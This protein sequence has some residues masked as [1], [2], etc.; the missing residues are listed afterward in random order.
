MRERTVS[1]RSFCRLSACLLLFFVALRGIYPGV[2]QAGGKLEAVVS[3]LPLK[4]FVEQIAGDRVKVSVMVEPGANPATYEPKPRQMAS[5]SHASMYFSIGVPFERTWLDRFRQIN[6]ELRIIPVQQGIRLYPIGNE[7]PGK[8]IGNRQH[9]LKDP[10][11]WLSPPLVMVQ[12]RNILFALMQDMPEQSAYLYDR[13]RK[14]IGLVVSTD[15][16]IMDIFK[17]SLKKENGRNTFLVFHPCWGYFAR[18]Y[19]L[20][21]LVIEQQG[22]EP[23]P[24]QLARITREAARAGMM[25]IFVQPQFS[26]R[27]ARAVADSIGA[28]LVPADPLAYDWDANLISVALRIKEALR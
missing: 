14:F 16:R 26:S 17:S 22:R 27:S 21:Q 18:A 24:S 15:L 9:V 2:A 25:S 6:P 8:N 13:Y 23:K 20:R 10:H 28:A 5:L 12:A 1:Y 19:G 7:K 4:Y 3:I 11:V